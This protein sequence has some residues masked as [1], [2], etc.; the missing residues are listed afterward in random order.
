MKGENNETLRKFCTGVCHFGGCGRCFLSG[1]YKVSWFYRSNRPVSG[2][3]ALLFVGYG[4]F[5]SIACCGKKFFLYQ[6][7]NRPGAC[8]LSDWI[9]SDSG[10]ACGAGRAPSSENAAGG[11]DECGNFWSCRAGPCFLGDWFN[12]DTGADPRQRAGGR[13]GKNRI[14]Y[15]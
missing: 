3:Y 15:L 9:R 8:R 13:A 7:K 11:G 6:D 1:I 12:S 14:G 4:V 5:P 2:T 10:D